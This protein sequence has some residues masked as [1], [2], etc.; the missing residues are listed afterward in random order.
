VDSSV[1]LEIKKFKKPGRKPGSSFH[2]REDEI[3]YCVR[4]PK[5]EQE[6]NE[7]YAASSL[8]ER[9]CKICP[10]ILF[11]VKKSIS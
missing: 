5:R 11:I 6:C 7:L 1:N 8:K 2:L 3:S 9:Y 10:C 4:Q